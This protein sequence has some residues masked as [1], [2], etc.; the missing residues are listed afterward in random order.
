MIELYIK[1][2]TERKRNQE[3]LAET[4]PW[5]IVSLRFSLRSFYHTLLFYIQNY[6]DD[7]TKTSITNL[8]FKTSYI[9]NGDIYPDFKIINYNTLIKNH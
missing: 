7:K 6:P 5:F 8:N 3:L 9:K 4:I 2:N 1:S